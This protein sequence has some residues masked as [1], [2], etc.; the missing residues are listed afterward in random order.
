M[1]EDKNTLV[2]VEFKKYPELLS[3]LDQMVEEDDSDRSKFIRNLVKQE[4]ARRA[5]LKQSLPLPKQAKRKTSQAA[6][7]VAVAG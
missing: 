7:L 4:I 5:T 2:H 6:Q 3:G 1:E